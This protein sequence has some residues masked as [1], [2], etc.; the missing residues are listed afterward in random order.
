VYPARV[1]NIFRLVYTQATPVRTSG[2]FQQKRGGRETKFSDEKK[3]AK[4]P[5]IYKSEFISVAAEFFADFLSLFFLSYFFR[6]FV[7]YFPKFNAAAFMNSSSFANIRAGVL[8]VETVG[9]G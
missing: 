6:S 4:R 1:S 7:L 5:R 9:G 2:T 3:L 8:L